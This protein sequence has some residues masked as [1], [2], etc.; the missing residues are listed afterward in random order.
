MNNTNPKYT[1][2]VRKPSF[3]LM[4]LMAKLGDNLIE[5]KANNSVND[6]FNSIATA[7]VG[8]DPNG[9]LEWIEL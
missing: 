6:T 1:Q 7:F 4:G 5:L 2:F 3:A 8:N 9:R